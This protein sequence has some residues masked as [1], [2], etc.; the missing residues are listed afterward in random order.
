LIELS[1]GEIADAAIR[2]ICQLSLSAAP[3]DLLL[4]QLLA[5]ADKW[6]R[7]IGPLGEIRETKTALSGLFGRF[8]ARAYL[9]RYHGFAYFEPV[10]SE[11]QALA[12]WPKQV[13][14]G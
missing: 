13:S 3:F 7:W 1:T 8:I 11:T 10:R 9:T 14:S 12:G 4:E 2:E 5:P 6:F